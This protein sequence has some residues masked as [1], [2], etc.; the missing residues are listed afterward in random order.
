MAKS[1]LPLVLLK[2]H[3]VTMAKAMAMKTNL[4]MKGISLIDTHTG[5]CSDHRWVAVYEM[6]LLTLES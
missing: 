5:P 3:V 4:T 1:T 2:T 6:E